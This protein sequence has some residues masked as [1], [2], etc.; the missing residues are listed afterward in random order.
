MLTGESAGGLATFHWTNYVAS[1][2]AK[3]TKFWSIPDSGVFMDETNIITKQN[4]Y[5]IWFQNI[6]KFSNEE[7]GT[8]IPE[9]NNKYSTEL[10]KC[11]FA[12]YIHPFITVPIFAPQ[13]LYDSWS[14]YNII[15]IRCMNSNS[16]ASCGTNEMKVIEAYRQST[17]QVLF[18]MASK[19]QNGVWG[20]ICVNHCYLS[21]EYYSSQNYRIPAASDYSLIRSVQL[22]MEGSDDNP[23]HLDFGS[24][25][26]NAPC[27]GIALSLN[28]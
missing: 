9:C 13:S 8:P 5:R 27:S 14:L 11:M 12:Q 16:L 2:V 19:N 28:K 15:G 10:W 25:P 6:L 1:R 7:V 17:M 21:N 23:R 20:P 18:E 26:N 4:S 24:W 3:E 22:W